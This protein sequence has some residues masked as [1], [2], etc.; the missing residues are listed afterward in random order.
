M[1]KIGII[2]AF[3][4]IISLLIVPLAACEG[5]QGPQGE[6]GPQGPQ[7]VQGEEGP[8]GPPGQPGGATGPQGPAGPAG[9]QGEQGEQGPRGLTGATGPMGPQGIQG[10]V[11]PNATIV[12]TDPTFDPYSDLYGAFAICY[13]FLGSGPGPWSRDAYVYGSNFPAGSYVSITICETDIILDEDVLVNACGAFRTT[14]TI[15]TTDFPLTSLYICSVKA[16]VDVGEDGFDGDDEL[17]ACW[18]L[19][20]LW[21]TE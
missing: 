21:E 1:K 11:G 19:S 3:L 20:I 12:V 5:P 18:P 4:M 16:W 17:Y 9:P 2:I 10:D 13:I 14:I 6:Q 8:P 15:S 7:G